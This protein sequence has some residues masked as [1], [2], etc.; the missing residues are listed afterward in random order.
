[1]LASKWRLWRTTKENFTLGAHLDLKVPTASE[2]HG[3]GA[4]HID[5]GA[6]LIATRHWERTSLDWNAG[7][8]ATDASGSVFGDDQGFFGQT[9]RHQLNEHWTLIG[10]AYALLPHKGSANVHFN[11]GAQFS[12]C[13]NLLLSALVGSAAGRNSPDFTSYLGLSYI[14]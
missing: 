2:D 10:E 8:I 6:V 4:G 12:T 1:M 14:S 9:V 11:C 13:D 3:L 7:Y 5:V